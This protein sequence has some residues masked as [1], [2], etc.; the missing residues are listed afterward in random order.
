[1]NIGFNAGSGFG[2]DYLNLNVS[3]SGYSNYG[4]Y[5]GCGGSMYPGISPQGMGGNPIN[6]MVNGAEQMA[7][8]AINFLASGAH[9]IT[10]VL[11]KI[12]GGLLGGL[13]GGIL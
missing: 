6:G 9:E 13:L 10:N 3:N 4:G 11:S 2:G 7:N 1:M 5:G 8:G 12:G